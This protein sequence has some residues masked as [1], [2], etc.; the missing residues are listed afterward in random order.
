MWFVNG[1]GSEETSIDGWVATLASSLK[2]SAMNQ[3]NK[4]LGRRVRSSK[5]FLVVST[6]TVLLLGISTSVFLVRNWSEQDAKNWV[7]NQGGHLFYEVN[8]ETPKP[9]KATDMPWERAANFL[10]S[11][12]GVEFFSNTRGVILDNQFVS[13]LSPLTKFHDLR[14]LAIYIDILP[15]ANLMVLAEL[16]QLEVLSIDHTCLTQEQVAQLA[17]VQNQTPNLDIKI[18]QNVDYL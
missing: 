14:V 8:T 2:V 16:G 17:E 11:A 10:R 12:F 13:D 9:S 18:G 6:L 5:K 1:F 15:E 3:T 7:E 4:E